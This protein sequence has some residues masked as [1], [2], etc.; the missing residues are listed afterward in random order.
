MAPPYDVMPGQ[1]SHVKILNM[2]GAYLMVRE[3]RWQQQLTDEFFFSF[4]L[5]F[6]TFSFLSALRR[7]RVVWSLS[8]RCCNIKSRS[9]I[10]P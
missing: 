2:R 10:D 1:W 8:P 7:E 3:S 5:D 4:C 9:L 6:C